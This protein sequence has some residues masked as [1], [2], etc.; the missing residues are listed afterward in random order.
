MFV[1]YQFHIIFPQNQNIISHPL[2]ANVSRWV[3]LSHYY[4]SLTGYNFLSLSLAVG[5]VKRQSM[6]AQAAF[7]SDSQAPFS[8]ATITWL[9]ILR[10]KHCPDRTD[11]STSAMFNQLLCSGV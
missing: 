1:K 9:P 7:R 3:S 6:V 8:F 2:A 5:I 4:S 11:I 10:S